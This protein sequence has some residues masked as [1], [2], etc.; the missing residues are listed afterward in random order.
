LDG[1][2]LIVEYACFE[3]CTL[4]AASRRALYWPKA[5]IHLQRLVVI[6]YC[7]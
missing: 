1:V 7:F 6:N 4:N 2:G 5:E 3:L